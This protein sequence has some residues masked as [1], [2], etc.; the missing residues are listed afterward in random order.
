M[1]LYKHEKYKRIVFVS[2]LSAIGDVMIAT[3]AI[4]K[5]NKNGYYPVFITSHAIVDVALKIIG[6]NA[7]ICYEKNKETLYYIDNNIVNMDFFINHIN[8][9]NV[10]RKNIFV[11]LQKTSRSKRAYKFVKNNVGILIEKKY[12]V[13]KNSLY[14]IC[15]ILLSWIMFSQKKMK[16]KKNI[17]RVHDLQENLIKEIMKNDNE[18]FIPLDEHEQITLLKEKNVFSK[19]II[20]YICL[21]PGASG[22]VKS[23]PK[24]KFRELIADILKNTD[25]SVVICG[26]QSE[27][28]L[29]EYLNFPQNSRVHN[30]V[31]Q[32]SLGKTID[33]IAHS[34][35]LVTN[36][37]F[38]AHAADIFKIPASVIFGSTSPYF[39]F[40]PLFSKIFIEYE[41]LAC[42]PCTRHGKGNCR[43][44]NLKCFQHIESKEVF[45]KIK[46]YKD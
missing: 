41:N 24:E 20:N 44:K 32:T 3:Q 13:S 11:D 9:I 27:I 30:L 36:D 38:A 8:N 28:Y 45:E 35:Y 26:S 10:S 19:N 7:F 17:I 16:K 4:A 33:I 29:G 18:N 46:K 25:Y 15:L 23:W 40:T 1:N 34:K 2:R 39:G 42:S 22:F 43:Y 14:R 5:L 37:S 6:L 12:T 21:F 31:N